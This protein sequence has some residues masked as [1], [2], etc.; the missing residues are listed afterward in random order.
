MFSR[1]AVAE[2][3]EV[4]A[5]NQTVLSLSAPLHTRGLFI[6]G[7]CVY[8]SVGMRTCMCVYVERLGGWCFSLYRWFCPLCLRPRFC[9]LP[10]QGRFGDALGGGKW[11]NK[12]L[13]DT[14]R[15][16][17]SFDFSLGLSPFIFHSLI[18]I[19]SFIVFTFAC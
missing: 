18:H 15:G 13:S 14:H 7:M 19:D 6:Q 17:I 5:V 4:V 2:V 9:L 3:T 16:F 8:V 1:W 11:S 10:V 12:L